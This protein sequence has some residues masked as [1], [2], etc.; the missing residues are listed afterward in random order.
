MNLDFVKNIELI[1]Y[2]F[3]V[4]LCI[5]C[6]VN[7]QTFNINSVNS[8][9]K[10]LIDKSIKEIKK[11]N[12]YYKGSLL[13][14]KDTIIQSDD[15]VRW[16]AVDFYFNNQLFITAESNWL[17]QDVISRVVVWHPELKT[18]EGI[19]VGGKFKDLVFLISFDSWKDF[20]DGFLGFK[21]RKNA[22]LIYFMN[23]EEFPQLA[24]GTPLSVDSIPKLLEIE[25]IILQK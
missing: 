22:N 16:E 6:T 15:D 5:G 10:S 3:I 8:L 20:P 21:D 2:I 13:V 23:I 18:N 9:E 7:Y 1:S 19:G 24:H 11:N 14:Q 4:L 17:N 25:N 12:F